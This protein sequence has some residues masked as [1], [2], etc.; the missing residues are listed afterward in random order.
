MA[1]PISRRRVLRRCSIGIAATVAGCAAPSNQRTT[2]VDTASP[3]EDGNWNS[4]VTCSLNHDVL[5]KNREHR[6]ETHYQYE[7]LS[8]T[9][10]D[11]FKRALEQEARYQ[12]DRTENAPPE[13]EYTDVVT[14]YKITYEEKTYVLGTWSGDGCS[15]NT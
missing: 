7:T 8:D 15:I 9:A 11:Y 12:N 4:S 5:D 13:F 1:T 2:N 10:Q 6:I 3:D 14:K